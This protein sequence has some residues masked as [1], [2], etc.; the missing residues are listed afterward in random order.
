[1]AGMSALGPEASQPPPLRRDRQG[2]ILGDVC[3]GLGRRLAIDPIVLR[4]AFIAGAAAG[5]LGVVAY[6]LAWVAIPAEGARRAG[7]VRVPQLP[8]GR[9]SWTVASGIGMLM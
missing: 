6:L 1:M 2:A 5:G 3:A 7:G 4:I 8:G 9:D